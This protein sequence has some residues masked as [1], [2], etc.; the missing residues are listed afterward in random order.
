MPDRVEPY[1]VLLAAKP[2]TGDDWAY[3]VKSDGY[4]LAVHIE[5]GK[6]RILTRGGRDSTSRFP[7]I[8]QDALEMG[9]DSAILDGEAVVLDERGASDFGALQRALG[10][11]G[12]MRSAA[13]A[14]LYAF[15]L[16]YFDG[17]DLQA[18]TLDERRD[19]LTT[20]IKPHGSIRMS[21]ELDA[22]GA[23]ICETGVLDGFGSHHRQAKGCAVSI[24]AGWRR[25][26]DLVGD[27]PDPR[28]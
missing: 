10:G 1:L 5:R 25:A 12:G 13:G 2:P 4:R 28:I 22:N 8:A 26:Q 24:R 19:M 6:V 3:E 14:I 27:V 11:R 15:D 18:L 9:L 23:E 21:E 16:L 20:A 7:T 17:R